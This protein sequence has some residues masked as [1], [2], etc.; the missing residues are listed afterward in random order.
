MRDR[1]DQT[2]DVLRHR[3]Y[4]IILGAYTSR[5]R[6]PVTAAMSVMSHDIGGARL[7]PLHEKR[8]EGPVERSGLCSKQERMRE[9]VLW[10]A[11]RM[12]ARELDGAAGITRTVDACMWRELARLMRVGGD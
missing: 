7:A 12:Q 4:C 5:F 2:A 8:R 1:E 9:Y 10:Q 3:R 6:L 11:G